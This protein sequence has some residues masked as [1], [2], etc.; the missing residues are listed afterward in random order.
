MN[1]SKIFNS[2]KNVFFRVWPKKIKQIAEE[3]VTDSEVILIQHE[4]YNAKNTTQKYN[5]HVKIEVELS[6]PE[7]SMMERG[8]KQ[9]LLKLVLYALIKLDSIIYGD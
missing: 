3:F 7:L 5:T 2:E 6:S 8:R 1:Q 4:K 9:N